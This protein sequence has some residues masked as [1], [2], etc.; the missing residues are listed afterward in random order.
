M[1]S[2]LKLLSLVQISS[3]LHFFSG[4]LSVLVCLTLII[5]DTAWL[6]EG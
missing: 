3:P 4:M 5:E 1:Q 6:L 2:H